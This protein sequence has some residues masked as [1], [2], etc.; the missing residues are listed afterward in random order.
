MHPIHTR[1][2]R[3]ATLTLNLRSGIQI[4]RFSSTALKHAAYTSLSDVRTT[5]LPSITKHTFWKGFLFA[6]LQHQLHQAS[7]ESPGCLRIADSYRTSTFINSSIH[8]VSILSYD[9]SIDSFKASSS[10]S[11]KWCFLFQFTASFLFLKVIK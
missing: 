3:H 1:I 10:Q 5:A 4:N 8:S 6:L 11:A 7:V 2:S 9:R